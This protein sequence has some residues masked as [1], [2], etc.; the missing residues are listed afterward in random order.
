MFKFLN[1]TCH[2]LSHPIRSW[3]NSPLNPSSS[4]LP[5]KIEHVSKPLIDGYEPWSKNWFSGVCCRCYEYC[6]WTWQQIWPCW[7]N[8]E[9]YNWRR[10]LVCYWS[11]IHPLN[12]LLLLPLLPLLS[13]VLVKSS[14]GLIIIDFERHNYCCCY[15]FLLLSFAGSHWCWRGSRRNAT[16]S[17]GLITIRTAVCN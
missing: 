6:L 17:K 3:K 9:N 8:A 1:S 12:T 15:Y 14:N 2:F 10:S 16:R 11:S 4:L 13:F 5:P 7:I